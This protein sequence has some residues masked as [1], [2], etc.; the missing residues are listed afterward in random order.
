MEFN[1]YHLIVVRIR[2]VQELDD[3]FKNFEEEYGFEPNATITTVNN[4][5]IFVKF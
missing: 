3:I 1:E 5:T 2:F 4:Q